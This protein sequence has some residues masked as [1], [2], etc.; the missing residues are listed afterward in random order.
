MKK[1]K[2]II[3][4]LIVFV[5]LAVSGCAKP[6]P[7]TTPDNEPDAPVVD[8]AKTIG[9]EDDKSEDE[10][11]DNSENFIDDLTDPPNDE[12]DDVERNEFTPSITRY[13]EFDFSNYSDYLSNL[14]LVKLE[15]FYDEPQYE[16]IAN[17]DYGFIIPFSIEGIGI[18]FLDKSG[19]VIC[20]P[21]N[22]FEITWA[23]RNSESDAGVYYIKISK[24]NES[25]IAGYWEVPAILVSA[26]GKNI[27]QVDNIYVNNQSM[28]PL[29]LYNDYISFAQNGKWGAMDFNGNITIPC[30]YGE[31]LRFFNGLAPAHIY[32]TENPK[33][34]VYV[35]HIGEQLFGY[36]TSAS[37][38]YTEYNAE[39]TINGRYATVYTHGTVSYHEYS[40]KDLP[41]IVYE[42][43]YFVNESTYKNEIR[44]SN[45]RKISNYREDGQWFWSLLGDDGTVYI[46]KQL[47]VGHF[48]EGS[49]GGGYYVD[50]E[51]IIVSSSGDWGEGKYGVYDLNG[52][53]IIPCE[54]SYITQIGNLFVL[55]TA[56]NESNIIVDKYGNVIF[57]N[58]IVNQW[59][60]IELDDDKKIWQSWFCIVKKE[61]VLGQ[62]IYYYPSGGSSSFP[63]YGKQ[64]YYDFDGNELFVVSSLEFI[65]EK[66]GSISK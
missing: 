8:L 40:D 3:I 53:E 14:P 34:Y 17:D 4:L 29:D 21:S 27:V 49:I 39:V 56:E 2:R 66:L 52:V 57:K 43:D 46:Y 54:Y 5:M 60:N 28:G 44:Y 26:D 15:R 37:P 47:G 22:K 35:N 50:G 19:K 63:L 51:F 11:I 59:G 36:F 24:E 55:Q 32:G 9:N 65:Y 33:Q 61:D 10:P 25:Y 1:T 31:P 38:F 48:V 12:P 20:E 64:T 18:G 6:E 7:P 62:V 16:L 23:W 45:G 30:Q 13:A 58:I 41:D 42:L